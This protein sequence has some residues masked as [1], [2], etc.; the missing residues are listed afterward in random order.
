MI[1]Y[2]CDYRINYGCYAILLR[3]VDSGCQTYSLRLRDC[4]S[5]RRMVSRDVEFHNR[6]TRMRS[7]DLFP[8]QVVESPRTR[9]ARRRTRNATSLLVRHI[10]KK[11]RRSPARWRDRHGAGYVRFSGT[12]IR[13]RQDCQIGRGRLVLRSAHWLIMP[14]DTRR[15]PVSFSGSPQCRRRP[16]NLASPCWHGPW[17]AAR[18]RDEADCPADKASGSAFSAQLDR[19]EMPPPS[20]V[21]ILCLQ[22]FL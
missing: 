14:S 5:M 22:Q 2:A 17:R 16:S 4:D 12:G 18:R 11:L 8:T 13:R 20:L 19:M 1:T 15:R 7:G 21:A 6:Q 3:N 9:R 10:R